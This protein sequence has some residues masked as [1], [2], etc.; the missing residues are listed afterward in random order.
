MFTNFSP[1]VLEVSDSVL[2]LR[3]FLDR[4]GNRIRDLLPSNR[5]CDHST[6]DAPATTSHTAA[7][8][9]HQDLHASCP[10]P[11]KQFVNHTKSCFVRESNPLHGSQLPSH[12]ANR[13]AILETNQEGT[14]ERPSK[15][16]NI[17]KVYLS[18]IPLV[19]LCARSKVSGCDVYVNLGENH[20]MTSLAL[21]EA[22]GSVRL[23]LT[24]NHP[25]PIP[26]FRTRAPLSCDNYANWTNRNLDF[27]FLDIKMRTIKLKANK[28]EEHNV[29][30]KIYNRKKSSQTSGAHACPP[31]QGVGSIDSGAAVSGAG[32]LLSPSLVKKT[33]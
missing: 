23:L 10:D 6:N 11:K 12:H 7:T 32:M 26:A 2:L 17:D 28:P 5:T 22:R 13:V 20:P 19:A 24:K 16:N 1:F 27:H 3:H 9:V 4:P 33:Y 21:S 31:P 15:Y 30:K 14:F 8:P 18:V 29:L 25:V